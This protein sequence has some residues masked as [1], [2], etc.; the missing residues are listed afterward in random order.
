VV[1]Y[2]FPS[3]LAISSFV[4][5]GLEVSESSSVSQAHVEKGFSFYA[6]HHSGQICVVVQFVVGL[7]V[8]Q[9]FVDKG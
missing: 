1:F 9:S 4:L 6:C 3:G 8:L 5:L 7:L 2:V